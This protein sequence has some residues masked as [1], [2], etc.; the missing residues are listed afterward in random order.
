MPYAQPCTNKLTAWY[1]KEVIKGFLAEGDN[2]L[3]AE[4]V[5]VTIH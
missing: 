5:R 3:I 1:S 4:E 2:V